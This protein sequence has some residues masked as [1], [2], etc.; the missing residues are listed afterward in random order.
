[1]KYLIMEVQL[2]YAVGLDEEGRFVKMPNMGYEVGQTVEDAVVFDDPLD[3]ETDARAVDGA[4]PSSVDE[5]TSLLADAPAS[6]SPR[7]RAGRAL[8]RRFAIF[9]AAASMFVFAVTGYAVW[10]TPVGTVR[11]R[12][13][14]AMSMSVNRFDRVVDLRGDNAD[15]DN[16][17]DGYGY[18]GKNVQDVSQG[19]VERAREQGYLKPGGLVRIGAD[20][21]NAAWAD[22]IARDL[23]AALT[24]AFDGDAD[25]ELDEFVDDELDA[26]DAGDADDDAGDGPAGA[27]KDAD[28]DDD[29]DDDDGSGPGAGSFTGGDDNDDG[30][31]GADGGDGGDKGSSTGDADDAGDA[32]NAGD[33]DDGVGDAGDDGDDSAAGGAA[34]DDGGDDRGDDDAVDSGEEDRAIRPGAIGALAGQ[35]G[36]EEGPGD[37]DSPHGPGDSNMRGLADGNAGIAG[38]K[39]LP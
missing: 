31:D 7:R 20:S 8:R 28:R 32:D 12:I 38:Q 14:P 2:S 4:L 17:I 6:A 21:D 27:D 25:V 3:L 19:L 35:G 24:D 16:L 30:D 26:D 39:R 22:A 29:A 34:D 10:R 9:A 13:N 1:M 18:Y 11:M 37:S 15:G 5:H 36:W 23:L 33:A